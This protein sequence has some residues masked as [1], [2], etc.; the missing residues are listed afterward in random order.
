MMSQ[1]KPRYFF[2]NI[3]GDA[4]DLL[5]SKPS[6]VIP[7]PFGW[8]PA[9]EAYRNQLLSELGVV[10]SCLPSL[11]YWVEESTQLDSTGD[12]IQ[13]PAHWKEFRFELDCKPWSWSQLPQ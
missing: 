12:S 8:D 7:V 9:T 5:A 6:D 11:I 10:V 2:Y 3:Y 1:Q 4:D 13:V